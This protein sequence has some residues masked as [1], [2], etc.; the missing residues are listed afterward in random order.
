MKVPLPTLFLALAI[1]SAAAPL[2]LNAGGPYTPSIGWRG[3]T[4][5]YATSTSKSYIGPTK[6]SVKGTWGPV[7]QSHRWATSGDLEYKIP[8]K[9]GTYPLFLMWSETWSGSA[10]NKRVFTVKVNGFAL[11]KGPIKKGIIDVFK[12]SGGLNKGLFVNAGSF[13]PKAGFIT[14]TLGRIPGKNNPMISGILLNSPTGDSLAGGEGISGNSGS[15]GSSSQVAKP[16]TPTVPNTTPTSTDTIEGSCQG[17]STVTGKLKP[18]VF[19][20]NIGGGSL[21]KIGFGADNTKYITGSGKSFT[22]NLGVKV[23]TQGTW[24]PVYETHRWTTESSLTYK[25]PLPAGKYS[26]SL[27]HA[28]TYFKSSGKRVFNIFING[29]KKE[30]AVDIFKQ[31]GFGRARYKTF[32]GVSSVGGF[33]TISLKKIIENPMLSAIVIKGNGASSLAIGGSSQASCSTTSG[34]GSETESEAVTESGSNSES[35]QPETDFKK[36]HF[37]HSVSGGPYVET[38]F[39]KDGIAKVNLDGS[40]SHS[41]KQ[42]G[43]ETGKIVEYKWTWKGLSNP[44]AASDGT[45]TVTSEKSSQLFPLGVTEVSLFV[46]DQFGSSAIETTTVTVNSAT[47]PGAYC[48]YYDMGSKKLTTLNLPLSVKNAPKPLQAAPSFDLTFPSTASFNVPFDSNTFSVR[49]VFFID[50]ETAGIY[51]YN[52]AHSGPVKI[53]NNADLMASSFSNSASIVTTTKSKWFNKGLHSWQIHYLRPA[54]LEGQLILLTEKGSLLSSALIRHDAGATLPVITGLSKTSTAPEGGEIVGIFGK[55]FVNGVTVKFGNVEAET[56]ETT[57]GVITARAPPGTGTVYVT[58][59]TKAGVSNKITF[60]YS[61]ADI[62]VN[63]LEEKLKTTTGAEYSIQQIA[64]LTYGPDFRLYCG[65]LNSKVHALSLNNNFQVTKTCTKSVFEKYPRTVLGVTFNPKSTDLKLYMSTSTIFWKDRNQFDSFGSGWTNGKVQSVTLSGP[66][67]CFNN[68][69]KDVVTGLPV[70]NHDHAINAITFLPNGKILIA[71][72][73]FT[74]GGVSIPGDK[75]GGVGSNPLAGAIVECGAWGTSVQYSNWNDPVK[76][77]ITGGACKTYATGFRN[78]FSMM[79]TTKRKLY[80]TDNGPNKSFGIFSTN[81][82]GG[83]TASKTI[84]DK[85]HLV[86]PGKWHGHPSINRGECVFEGSGSVKPLKSNL[87][88]STNGVHEYRANTFGGKL[89]GNLF[90]AKFAIT[91]N[92]KLSRAQLASDGSIKTNGFTNIFLSNSGLN[93]AEGPRGELIMPRV[94]QSEIIVARP[95]YLKPK[96]TFFLSVMPNRGPA[97][98]GATVLISG[99]LLGMAPV[100]KFGGKVCSDVKVIDDDSFTCVT[101]TGSPDSQVDVS[102]DGSVGVS[103]SDG[104]DYWYY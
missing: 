73:G 49:C 20:M 3:D 100:A 83:N 85:L 8:V 64:S 97:S 102:V 89:K 99:H 55:A 40:N 90:I 11:N 87:Q 79:Y 96:N 72:G 10:S 45:V 2:R 37:A 103:T 46:M 68:D 60:I 29:Q 74:N 34:S 98:G 48:Y 14:I 95:T 57:A 47:V 30:S 59:T 27:M 101:P 76:A 81:C 22:A 62:P 77:K 19:V 15:S 32:S 52:L 26:I 38:D 17:S 80:A 63:F 94:Y 4:G 88:S 82:N 86:Q 78:T 16:F 33:I 25:I 9:E 31:V 12:S 84:P 1:C 36:E 104:I 66:N 23:L 21:S 44:K 92:G 91:G 53:F 18:D 54:G 56:V 69:L 6:V 65:A 75:L 51:K 67:G 93:I 5:K 50:V 13:S 70:S 58:V 41:H 35:K 7:Y 71:V 39:D 42:V 43:A 61:E 28:E 24:S